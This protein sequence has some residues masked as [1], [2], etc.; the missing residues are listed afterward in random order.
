MKKTKA[1]AKALSS[2]KRPQNQLQVSILLL[3]F[4]DEKTS[5]WFG[6]EKHQERSK[7]F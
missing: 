4:K 6:V 2:P 3:S 1:G 5:F 7:K